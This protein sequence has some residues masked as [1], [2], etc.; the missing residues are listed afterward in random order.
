MRHQEPIKT[1]KKLGPS[2]E[3]TEKKF[4]AEYDP[5]I[6]EER[7]KRNNNNNVMLQNFLSQGRAETNMSVRSN[8]S[9]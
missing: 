9:P 1:V 5:I 2:I 3:E 4:R 7:Y 8:V 6:Y